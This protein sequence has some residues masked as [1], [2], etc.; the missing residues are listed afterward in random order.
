MRP[1]S[2][3]S[4]RAQARRPVTVALS[5]GPPARPGDR[6][7][8]PHGDVVE[9]G[10]QRHRTQFRCREGH[11]G[12]HAALRDG[13]VE[14]DGRRVEGEFAKAERHQHHATVEA[15]AGRAGPQPVR[16]KLAD[17]MPRGGHAAAAE[18]QAVSV[19]AAA[20]QPF[21]LGDD[22]AVQRQRAADR[23]EAGA[24]IADLGKAAQSHDAPPDEV[25]SRGIQ[26]QIVQPA[27]FTRRRG[28]GRRGCQR[29]DAEKRESRLEAKHGRPTAWIWATL[30]CA[31]RCWQQDDVSHSSE[32][33]ADSPSPLGY[34]WCGSRL[35][36]PVMGR[37]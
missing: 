37:D 8:G 10:L 7:A 28:G 30:A 15:E 18:H 11:E 1:A 12:G 5:P 2:A 27:L 19:D 35:D 3:N 36:V 21:R 29:Q 9:I 6:R 33:P 34:S 14:A 32:W 13:V 25:V 16:G 20:G 26:R 24:A 31:P 4:A 22:D 23:V 17:Q